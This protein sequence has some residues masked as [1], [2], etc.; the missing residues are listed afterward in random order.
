MEKKMDTFLEM[1]LAPELLRA[2]E[3]LG[4]TT[5]TPVQ[6]KTI[7]IILN[8]ASDLV[9][10]AQTG[11]GKTA[12]FGLPVLQ[13]SDM[14]S[15]QLQTL[16]LCPTR[17]L[18]MQITAD[19][20]KYSK[21]IPGFRVVPV[22]GGTN[23]LTQIRAVKDNPQVIIGTPGRVMD[24]IRRKILK[25]SAIRW[26][27]LD[28][29]DEMLNMGFSEDLDSILAETPKERQTLLF[30]ATM[31]RGIAEIAGKYMNSPEE[32]SLG[33]RNAGA[34]NVKHEYYMVHAKDR[35]L[36]LKRIVDMNP[37]IYGI[38]FCRT[39]I[40]T[41]E[42]ADKLM[43]DGYNADAL[44]GD[45]SQVQRDYVMNKFRIKNLQLLVATDVAARGLD[46]QELTHIINY[47][48]PDDPEIYV[49]RSG[50]TG[51][52]GNSGVSVSIIHTR[53]LNRIKDLE[54]MAR[55]TFERKMVPGGKEIC[56]KQLFKLVDTVEKTVVNDEIEKY[57]PVIY[58]KLE[59]LSREELIKHFISVEFNRFLEYYK[60]APDLNA[61]GRSS[62]ER[63]ERSDRFERSDRPER[64]R[65]S[66]P[67]AFTR[68]HINIG[69][70]HE[71]NAGSLIAWVNRHSRGK[72]IGIGRIEILRNFSF[73]EVDSESATQVVKDLE[74][75]SFDGN[76]VSIETSSPSGS[77]PEYRRND[78][79]ART[80]SYR[81]NESSDRAP[82]R[83]HD[84]SMYTRSSKRKRN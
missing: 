80:S 19:F 62:G 70:K 58:K 3:E 82:D 45:L 26:V 36:A 21:F 50:R 65:Q 52:A 37:T 18:C 73:F 4:F 69:N 29:A 47:N 10:L 78:S 12:A 30:S 44:H 41:K 24:L 60:D 57:L 7:P 84:S 68:L 20:V 17:E 33:K 74:G 40:E 5:P 51:R 55:K 67:A 83:R 34:D 25:L 11:T 22:Y 9:V 72:R 54:R 15:Q 16:V 8:S 32:V 13:L 23:I 77:A 76:P 53:E 38:V 27:V 1:G 81:R 66:D 61:T 28:E 42:V 31:P 46:V 14:K 75:T 48:L 71:L 56:E 63:S 49:H 35:Y 39:R 2:V 64:S 43:Q 59:W 6:S 79:S